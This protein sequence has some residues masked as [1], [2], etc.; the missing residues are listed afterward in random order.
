MTGH[1]PWLERKRVTGPAWDEIHTGTS[2]ARGCNQ[3][4]KLYSLTNHQLAAGLSRC[5]LQLGT[6]HTETLRSLARVTCKACG[7]PVNI[8]WEMH[9]GAIR[10]RWPFPQPC[11]DESDFSWCWE[12]RRL[13]GPQLCQSG[14]WC[15]SAETKCNCEM[16]WSG[17]CRHSNRGRRIQ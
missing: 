7:R 10:A 12:Q 2:G 3:L 11:L 8:P 14:S 5:I 15:H 1:C 9:V 17:Q 4:H 16:G 6:W 13:V